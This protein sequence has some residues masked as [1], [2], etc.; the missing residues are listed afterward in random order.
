VNATYIFDTYA[1]LEVKNVCDSDDAVLLFLDDLTE[2]VKKGTVSYPDAVAKECR[3]F[4][5]ADPATVWVNACTGNRKHGAVPSQV[6]TDVLI[7]CPDIIDEEQQTDSS[8]AETLAL[9]YHLNAAKPPVFIVSEESMLNP[10]RDTLPAVTQ[11]IGIS[12]VSLSDFM[13][14]TGLSHLL[15]A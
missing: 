15:A 14:A 2:R 6:L 5:A 12:V 9:A 3:A 13:N 8:Q 1:L 11:N 4:S 10:T 7:K